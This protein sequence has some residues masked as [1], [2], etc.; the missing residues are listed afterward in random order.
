ML[1]SAYG[2]H[3]VQNIRRSP[4][5]EV[6][7][8]E[9][10][11]REREETGGKEYYLTGVINLL[12]DFPIERFG[13]NV[14]YIVT[15]KDKSTHKGV[16]IIEEFKGATMNFDTTAFINGPVDRYE[17]ETPKLEGDQINWWIVRDNPI[18]IKEK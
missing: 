6:I 18:E 7:V 13:L 5:I 11:I 16:I 9:R 8:E 12:E 3:V 15:F 1:T 14:T 17:G 10:G 4:K 2:F